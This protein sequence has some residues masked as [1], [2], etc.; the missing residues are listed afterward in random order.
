MVDLWRACLA[1]DPGA[2][3]SAAKVQEMLEALQRVKRSPLLRRTS[4]LHVAAPV[5]NMSTPSTDAPASS[6]ATPLPCTP[7]PCTLLQNLERLQ[8]PLPT[9]TG[10]IAPA[11]PRRELNCRWGGLHGF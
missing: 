5:P 9:D 8:N 4:G 6:A 10:K 3:P 11:M 2:R 1:P 7:Q